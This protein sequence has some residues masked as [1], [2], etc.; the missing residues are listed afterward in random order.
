MVFP[1]ME[2]LMVLDMVSKK[3]YSPYM[4]LIWYLRSV[5][6]GQP[7]SFIN[8]NITLTQQFCSHVAL[9]LTNLHLEFNL[10]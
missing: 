2:H 4:T 7:G 3:P 6:G 9:E 5:Y 10:E 8:S 1:P